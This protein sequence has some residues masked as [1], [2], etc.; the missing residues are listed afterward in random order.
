LISAADSEVCA[1]QKKMSGDDW[2]A[3][4][5]ACYPP[6]TGLTASFDPSSAR[7]SS[8]YD[9][10]SARDNINLLYPKEV[11]EAGAKKRKRSVKEFGEAGA[12]K[13]K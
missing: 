10:N 4:S 11:S 12:K 7:S 6:A 13:G 1:W 9:N 3:T 5:A 8:V 2:V